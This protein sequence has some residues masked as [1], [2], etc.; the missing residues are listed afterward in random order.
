VPP[1]DFPQQL[2]A[3]GVGPISVG[4]TIVAT[5]QPYE[6]IVLETIQSMGLELQ[7]IFNKGAVMILPTGVNKATGL[8]AA[9]RLL[10]LS[11][12]EV[13]A[14][15]DAENDHTFLVHSRIG[16]AVSN[17]LA[18][19]KQH[20]EIVTLGDHGRGVQEVVNRILANELVEL[21]RFA[22]RHA[23]PLARSDDRDERW[24]FP[25]QDHLVLTGD[26]DTASRAALAIMQKL[27][28]LGYQFCRFDCQTLPTD[29]V[30]TMQVVDVGNDEQ[31]P[32]TKQVLKQLQ[33]PDQSVNVRLCAHGPADRS[34][35][36]AEILHQLHAFVAE[37]GRPHVVIL[38]SL[39]ELASMGLSARDLMHGFP[40]TINFAEKP[41]DL[42]T[43]SHSNL[44]MLAVEQ[45]S[46]ITTKTS[47]L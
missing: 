18:S 3:Q 26:A 4:R 7:V 11:R 32:P 27:D 8:A 46:L 47:T 17:A 33:R 25:G 31:L 6:S 28:A 37:R 20:A 30:T 42:A 44:Q 14:I 36:L 13:V 35:R 5:W 41:G 15:G 29:E 16:V 10:E 23:I 19:L 2:A 34:Q 21:D 39:T 43:V 24:W 12:H 40:S 22:T 45:W 1:P 9:L 38:P